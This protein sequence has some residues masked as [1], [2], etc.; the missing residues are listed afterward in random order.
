M[1]DGNWPRHPDGRPKK[2]GE[3]TREESRA[4]AEAACA[5]LK[6]E[7]EQP[8]VQRAFAEMLARDP[9]GTVQ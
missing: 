2:V 5:R 1:A 7:F 8:H 9:G 3:M 6:A 4:V